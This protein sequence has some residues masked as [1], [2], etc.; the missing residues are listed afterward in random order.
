VNKPQHRIQHLRDALEDD[1]VNG[2]IAQGERLDEVRLS[3][4]FAVSRT[5]I[6][7][8]LRQLAATGLVETIPRRG[9]FVANLG[10]PE[11]I[12]MFEVMAELE[13]MCGRLG[14][15]RIAAEQRTRLL[16]KLD[17]CRAA[18]EAG[19]SDDYYYE[20]E[21]FHG[22]IYELSY[23]RF[24]ADQAQQLRN[25]LKPYRRLQ[26]RVPQRMRSSF[27]EHKAIVDAILGGNEQNA[28]LLLKNH[29]LIQG[30]RFADLV[31][32][33]NAAPKHETVAESATA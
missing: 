22:V 3:Q 33:I 27:E 10:L 31:S 25:R 13:G 19:N 16:E 14:A 21:Q 30:E 24:L 1:I 20:N 17:T 2:R 32:M 7:E 11:I 18:A 9:T 26:L 23:N 4:R 6:R 5:P 28:E 29:V 12:E 15:R 8:A